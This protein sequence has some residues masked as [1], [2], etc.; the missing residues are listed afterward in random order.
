MKNWDNEES[1]SVN[2]FKEVIKLAKIGIYELYVA[3]N[4]VYWSDVTKQIV[5]VSTDFVPTM[6][7][8][9]SFFKEGYYL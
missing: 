6:E 1:A 9:K 8:I 5:Q 7:N 2:L 3:T 4:E